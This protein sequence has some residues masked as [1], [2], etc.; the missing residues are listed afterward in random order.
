[1]LAAL[2]DVTVFGFGL[3]SLAFLFGFGL[4]RLFKRP[5][6]PH[7]ESKWHSSTSTILVSWPVFALSGQTKPCSMEFLI[8][9]LA[10]KTKSKREPNSRS[11]PQ[12]CTYTSK[13]TGEIRVWCRL[14][15]VQFL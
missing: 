2:W 6:A 9:V 8:A 1:M 10:L 11:V 4:L 14:T 3:L 15:A 7:Q 13:D 5:C 12:I